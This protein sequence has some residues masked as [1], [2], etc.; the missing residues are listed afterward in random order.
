[1]SNIFNY[2]RA[3][4]NTEVKNTAIDFSTSLYNSIFGIQPE[5][6]LSL[7][8]Q[9]ETERLKYN[10]FPNSEPKVQI[11]EEIR[12]D[13]VD[14]RIKAIKK[15]KKFFKK[16]TK[17][18]LDVI[19][20][21]WQELY[22]LIKINKGFNLILAIN[23]KFIMISSSDA[24]LRLKDIVSEETAQLGEE[25]ASD[26]EAIYEYNKLE[27][28]KFILEP[29]KVKIRPFG[30]YFTWYHK[31]SK[32]DLS[33]Y[34]IYQ[35]NNNPNYKYNCLQQAFIVGG[36]HQDDIN[37][38]LLIFKTRDIPQKDLKLVCE[39]LNIRIKLSKINETINFGTNGKIYNIGL[40][41]NHYF[42]NETIGIT[43]FSIKNY[44]EVKDI[45]DFR[46]ISGKRNGKHISTKNPSTT[47]FKIIK[48]LIENKESQL[49]PITFENSDKNNLFT[50]SKFG[51]QNYKELPEI[52]F[53][54][55]KE[56]TNEISPEEFEKTDKINA[57]NK[58][59]YNE[60]RLVTYNER[61]ELFDGENF[62]T[63]Y[64]DTETTTD[65]DIHRPYLICAIDQNNI[66][67]SQ[68]GKNCILK[69]LLSLKNNTLLIAHN[70]KYDLQFL[71]D[72]L[73]VDRSHMIK[74]GS[75]IKNF[76][77]KF[78]NYDTKMTH[79]IIFKDS[80]S[81][82]P[83]QLKEFG[84]MFELQVKKEVMPYAIYNESS[85]NNQHIRI[86]LAEKID[87]FTG[88]LILKKD[89]YKEFNKNIDD[90]GLR[91][92]NDYFNHIEYSRLY[93]EMDCEVLKQGYEIFRLQMLEVTGEDVNLCIS[94]PQMANLFGRKRGVFKDCYEISS[95]PR[96][97]I[98]RC[99]VG[100][101]VMCANNK[102]VVI[103]NKN[104]IDDFDGVSLYPSAMK[105]MLGMLKGLPKVI[106][107]RIR[108]LIESQNTNS[109][110]SYFVEIE[111]LDIG[112]NRAF[113]LISLK[114]EDTKTRNFS[115][116]IR[117]EGIYVDKTSLEDLIKFQKIKFRVIR[118]Y[119]FDEGHNNTINVFMEELFQE[120]L[121]KKKEGNI[122]QKVYKLIL[123]AFYG[124]LI[125]KP[126]EYKFSFKN[127]VEEM[128]KHVN[129]N[130]NT[131]KEVI[132]ISANEEKFMIKS[133][134]CIQS[135]YNMAHAGTEILSM[136]KRIM[137]EVMCLAEDINI[138][139]YY[140]DTDSMHIDARK[141]KEGLSGIDRLSSAY[142][143]RYNR[144]LVGEQLGQFHSDFD[145][146]SDKQILASK[147]IFLG[148]KSYLDVIPTWKNG[149]ETI[150]YHMRMKGIPTSCLIDI[151]NT[152]YNG[153]CFLMYYD[154]Y[155]GKK[156]EFNL[157]DKLAFKTNNN[158]TTGRHKEFT[159]NIQF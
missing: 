78:Y 130:F 23:N 114:D 36:M 110:S 82:I 140:Q 129:Y 37:T 41:D 2:F 86:D 155:K 45:K 137:N 65:G 68:V 115:N 50:D 59:I 87:P 109:L 22:P 100:G 103:N 158:F 75:Q 146:K 104:E 83:M 5:D 73:I 94:L 17:G 64:F 42:L 28:L 76:T 136:S 7:E 132:C 84:S 4:L 148:K 29:I 16:P 128:E 44:E 52:K 157:I 18:S 62:D 43:I 47:S 55:I 120:R 46:T 3:F 112:K 25:Y 63:M 27:K 51:Q 31:L 138:E 21:P 19:E 80:V 143:Q 54:H 118:G 141:N 66:K 89:A 81:F 119:Y 126:I 93:C 14:D 142:K 153:D 88:K 58:M 101:R 20:I 24:L 40:I 151:A 53:R 111:V 98:Q 30:G 71:I 32:I 113:P 107:E 34:Q 145:F 33:K 154:L 57:Y 8:N 12:N 122:I 15:I 10:P 125:Q 150:Q 139:L 121:K 61:G 147:S 35:E 135:H 99:A 95:I 116:D 90:W 127:S 72:Y 1:M 102:K 124:K 74:T 26:V 149:V 39:R 56:Y 152:N 11:S 6:Y 91:I 13:L 67:T 134:N 131:I 117:G 96:E 60:A 159:R 38:A 108:L 92:N 156:I 77:A 97:F 105:R 123:N 9:E 144:E 106:N 69:F 70:L 85:I 79:N 133:K 49:I 48:Y